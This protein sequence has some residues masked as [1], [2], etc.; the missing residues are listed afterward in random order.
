MVSEL[1]TLLYCL[2]YQVYRAA[3]QGQV[4]TSTEFQ[5]GEVKLC[6]DAMTGMEIGAGLTDV[7]SK[8]VLL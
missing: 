8:N 7:E 1:I 4:R 2:P 5:E 6:T 3:K